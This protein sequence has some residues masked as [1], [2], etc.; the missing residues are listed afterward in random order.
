MSFIL[1]ISSVFW[2][3]NLNM[4]NSK[5]DAEDDRVSYADS[6]P[7]PETEAI[8]VIVTH[9][10][11][12]KKHSLLSKSVS[13]NI[14]VDNRFRLIGSILDKHHN[15]HFLSYSALI[16]WLNAQRCNLDLRFTI[17]C[18]SQIQHCIQQFVAYVPFVPYI[19]PFIIIVTTHQFIFTK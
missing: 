12:K 14:Y 11:N 17:I 9:H 6:L 2:V 10:N 16:L 7:S 19:S 15:G 18:L 13:L 4:S 8:L 1:T 5:G 3:L